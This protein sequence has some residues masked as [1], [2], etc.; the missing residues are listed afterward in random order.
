[1]KNSAQVVHQKD[2]TFG[3]PGG[4]TFYITQKLQKTK[5]KKSTNLDSGLVCW[6]MHSGCMPE[7]V[8]SADF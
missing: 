3:G 7:Q 5:T 4:G 6:S 8:S 2:Q 1:M